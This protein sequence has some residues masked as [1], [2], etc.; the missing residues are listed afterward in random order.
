MTN[1]RTL[2]KAA[3]LAAPALAFGLPSWA[4]ASS[5]TNKYPTK[6]P[7][8]IIPYPPGGP[9]DTLARILSQRVSEG[10]PHAV[11]ID[12]VPGAGTAIGVSTVARSAPDGYTFGVVNSAF[13][14]NTLL[15]KNL[16]YSLDQLTGITQMVYVP[17]VLA[18]NADAPYD[19]I[20][21]LVEFA[22]KNPGTLSFATPG[23]GGTSHLAGE[24]LNRVANIDLL[25]IG[26]KG[27]APAHTDVVGGR[28]PLLI[29]P[30]LSTLPLVNAGRLKII[31]VLSSERFPSAPDY[32][33]V[34]ETFPGFD[35][36]T[37]LGL[38]APADTPPAIIQT[39]A[40]AF[41]AALKNPEDSRRI[42]ELG[43]GVVGSGP[44]AFNELIRREKEL[45]GKVITDARI[46]IE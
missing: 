33:T 38:V 17:L 39:I 19:T 31:A 14:T 13:V 25:H 20:E 18:A 46:E 32:P 2:L 27:S 26:Y 37:F 23:A 7:R 45:W 4:R 8:L 36:S 43:M 10:W 35:V 29:D 44:A 41:D 15:R 16:G 12:Y 9:T 34:A 28:V 30:L 1:R 21:E 24:L 42:A 11:L 6:Q 40:D 3:T 5:E 22:R